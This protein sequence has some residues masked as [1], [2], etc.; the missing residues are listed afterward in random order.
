M[1][2]E[3]FGNGLELLAPQF[4]EP[5][6]LAVRAAEH[7]QRATFHDPALHLL[8]EH[9]P[10]LLGHFGFGR[11]RAERA[12]R[13]ERRE[14]QIDVRR[15][16]IDGQ[17]FGQL[18]DGQTRLQCVPPFDEE[19]VALGNLSGVGFRRF[20][21]LS[22][23]SNTSSVFRGRRLTSGAVLSVACFRRPSSPAGVTTSRS[24][25]SRD[26]CVTGSNVRI[27][28]NLVTVKFDAHRFSSRSIWEKLTSGVEF[29]PIDR[30]EPVRV[31]FSGNEIESIR[32][33]D[34]VTQQSREKRD[35]LVV[36]PVGELGLLKQATDKTAPLV[37]L[38]A[39][40]AAGVG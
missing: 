29:F 30:E 25:F 12:K 21:Q 36:T 6:P 18:N 28:S 39:E 23:S 13:I 32:T 31:E 40:Y 10:H 26:C 8:E 22:G 7:V 5:L 14:P 9:A 4:S 24:R 16:R 1:K 33:F 11:A 35:R 19:L 15:R 3:C 34:P 20:R 38:A 17:R 27:D 37:T 2:R